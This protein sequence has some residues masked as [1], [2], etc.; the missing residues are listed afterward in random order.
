MLA[1]F[2]FAFNHEEYVCMHAG[3]GERA[4]RAERGEATCVS[5]RAE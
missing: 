5:S 4:E 2:S 3:G 1:D